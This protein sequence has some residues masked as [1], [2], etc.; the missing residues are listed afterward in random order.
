MTRQTESGAQFMTISRRKLITALFGTTLFPS[1]TLAAGWEK[2]GKRSVRLVG[3]HDVIPVTFLRGDFRRIQLRVR[4]NGIF[5]NDL[6]VVYANGN[7]DRIPIQNHIPKGGE[8][9]VID[10]RGGERII[11]S[12]QL[13]YRSVR[14]S[15]GRAEVSVYGRN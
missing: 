10:L 4:E 2:L 11:R 1:A 8:S 13:Y 3:D 7:S 14:N 9:R 5:I 6:V 15:K 12:V